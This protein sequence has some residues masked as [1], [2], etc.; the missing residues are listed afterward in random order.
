MAVL[1]NE[2]K[3]KTS[4]NKSHYV[5]SYPKEILTDLKLILQGRKIGR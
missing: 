5:I 1:I 3:V 4:F 2:L